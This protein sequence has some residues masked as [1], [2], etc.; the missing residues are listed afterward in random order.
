M[1]RPV[2]ASPSAHARLAELP[3]D[4]VAMGKPN[5][6]SIEIARLDSSDMFLASG[7]TPLRLFGSS[8]GGGAYTPSGATR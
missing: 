6:A 2:S 7:D 3:P 8:H 1:I 5:V 4:T